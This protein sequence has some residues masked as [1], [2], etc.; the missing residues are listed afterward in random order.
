[1]EENRPDDIDAAAIDA[2]AAAA[3]RADG[4]A[5]ISEQGLL[6]VHASPQDGVRH[7]TA[8]TTSSEG[9][10]PSLAGYAQIDARPGGEPA[11]E[12][13]VNPAVRRQGLGH[14]LTTQVLQRCPAARIWSHGMLP[15]SQEIADTHALVAVRDLWRMSRP[16]HGI[17]DREP[18]W[19]PGHRV[20]T[21]T[22]EDGPDWVALN[23][24]SFAHHGEQGRMS[25][26]D[27][28]TREREPWFDPAGF[29]LVR[30]AENRVVAFHWTKVEDGIGEVY[31]V[32]VDPDR[33]GLGLGKAVT[34]VGLSHLRARGLDT[35]ELYVDGDNIAAIRTY[36]KLG[37]IRV[38]QDV[39][40]AAAM[41]R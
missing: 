3:T 37:F 14:E 41:P 8:Y 9:D 7:L 16:L 26:D 12:L 39:Q 29:F 30:D 34:A 15:G 17:D 20:T 4:V 24:R 35:V 18:T 31:V 28:R 1:M 27:L 21:Y 19:P 36:Q 38:G 6:N 2:L 22:P 25:L 5:P 10:I 23:A 11:A 13:V 40:W 33:Q 32:G